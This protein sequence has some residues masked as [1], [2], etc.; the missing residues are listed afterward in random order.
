MH[1]LINQTKIRV[2]RECSGAIS[3][4]KRFLFAHTQMKA[5]ALRRKKG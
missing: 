1:Y 5:K 3:K 2:K 4:I